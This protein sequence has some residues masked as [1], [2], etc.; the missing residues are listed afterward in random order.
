VYAGTR[1]A[2]LPPRRGHRRGSRCGRGARERGDDAGASR[3]PT[4]PTRLLVENTAGAGTTVGA[5]PRRIGAILAGI[6]HALRARAG[7]GLDTCH[8]Y[9][10]GYD[11]ARDAAAVRETLD[12]FERAA[13][14]P[15]AFFHLNDSEGALGSNRTATR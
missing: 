5:R 9:A 1:A 2:L 8:L 3:A 10:S 15:P 4:G 13:G 14:A 11:L 12:A 7:Y 6:P